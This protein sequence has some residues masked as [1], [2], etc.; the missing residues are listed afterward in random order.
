MSQSFDNVLYYQLC[1]YIASCS[2]N[3]KLT[4]AAVFAFAATSVL[5]NPISFKPTAVSARD[6][7]ERNG[8]EG[9]IE[10]FEKRGGLGPSLFKSISGK[11][12]CIE[13][14]REH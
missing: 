6:L 9:F 3:M 4:T 10:S 8:S 2:S 11:L 14:R 7:Y 5:G 13:E 1:A 12:D